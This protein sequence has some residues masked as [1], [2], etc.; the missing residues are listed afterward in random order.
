MSFA[1][2]DSR[3]LESTKMVIEPFGQKMS[4]IIRKNV[5]SK[6]TMITEEGGKE[7]GVK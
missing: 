5:N 2:F 4:S 7:N 1:P 6:L 3:D